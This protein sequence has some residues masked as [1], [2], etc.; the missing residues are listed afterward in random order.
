[1]T[2]FILY[3]WANKTSSKSSHTTSYRLKRNCS[4]GSGPG[5]DIA[6]SHLSADLFMSLYAW[7]TLDVAW[8]LLASYS[9]Y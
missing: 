3:S 1:M 6:E 2:G 8:E 9:P 7:N 5:I 4:R